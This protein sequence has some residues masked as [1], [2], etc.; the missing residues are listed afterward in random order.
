M[1]LEILWTVSTACLQQISR[2]GACE[3]FSASHNHFFNSKICHFTMIKAEGQRNYEWFI[4]T[5]KELVL[6]LEI[7]LNMVPNVPVALA[8]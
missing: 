8:A 6:L 5:M 2:F 7:I 1:F 3:I 4:M